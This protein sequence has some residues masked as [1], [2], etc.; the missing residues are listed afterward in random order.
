[1]KT[2]EQLLKLVSKSDQEK[3]QYLESFFKYLPDTMIEKFRYI[4]VKKNEKIILGGEEAENVYIVLDGDI[5]GVD[6]F[7]AGST[8]SFVDF[9]KMY[10]LG[11]FELFSDRSEYM[12]SI[13]ANRDCKLL[14]ISAE[15][16]MKWLVCDENALY[17][18]LKNV[19]GIL[20]SERMM[21]RKYL[22][23]GCKERVINYLI[24]YYDKN[25][26]DS[27]KNVVV[28]L[29]QAELSEK[30]G[31]NIRSIQ[32]A[33]AS[34]ESDNLITIENRKMLLSHEQYLKLLNDM[35]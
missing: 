4:E 22:R 7:Q 29:T 35:N 24:M 34:L 31:F 6:Y 10:I 21:D 17:M 15:R 2:K 19:M 32:R 26:K 11:D 27:S 14:K 20:T 9:S 28:S 30:V 5:K 16:Y 25:R 3:Y 1:M 33:I 13:Y 18:R 8:Y 23:M 12:I